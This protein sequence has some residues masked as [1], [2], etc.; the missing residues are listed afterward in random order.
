MAYDLVLIL[1]LVFFIFGVFIL[2]KSVEKL[3]KGVAGIAII[4][5]VSALVLSILFAGIDPENTV[6]GGFASAGDLGAVALGTTVGAT[7]FLL[8][9]ALGI[10]ALIYPMKV[11]TPLNLISLMLL[12]PIPMVIFMY[13]G[14][15]SRVEG[16]FLAL[17]YIPILCYIF[18]AA[19]QNRFMAGSG[20]AAQAKKE[21]E[22][23]SRAYFVITGIFGLV[24]ISLGGWMVV[25]GSKGIINSFGISQTVFGM[26]FVAAATALEEIFIE[27]IPAHKG[28]PEISVGNIIGTVVYFFTANI[29]II[30]FIRPVEVYVQVMQ[31]HVPFMIGVLVLTAALIAR[32][33]IGRME[34]I[35]LICI[36]LG[37]LALNWFFG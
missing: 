15:I 24:G 6:T 19:R 27:T 14:V 12:S 13:N 30:A 28:H 34:G 9:V 11:K 4:F 21:M 7:I 5:G 3:V 1:N 23:K 2:V 26:V 31:F 29:G 22:S 36:Y 35:L 16:A 33:R 10:A 37:Y 18:Q 8:C 32:K 20:H 17:L 25:E